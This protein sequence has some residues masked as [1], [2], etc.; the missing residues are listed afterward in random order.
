MQILRRD[1]VRWLHAY[2]IRPRCSQGHELGLPAV[3][4]VRGAWCNGKITNG[5]DREVVGNRF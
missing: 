5:D 3:I 4:V 1:I 2:R